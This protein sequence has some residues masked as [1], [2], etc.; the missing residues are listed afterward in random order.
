MASN[1]VSGIVL[2]LVLLGAALTASAENDD[3]ANSS[4]P[5]WAEDGWNHLALFVGITD[6]GGDTG[7]SLG[8]DYERRLT[9]L[10]GIGG[11]LEY[12]GSDL[13][14]GLAA[15]SFNWHVWKELKVLAAPGVEIEDRSGSF[16]LRLAVE[17]GFDI[18]KG[19]EAAP[20]L[21]F[22][23]TSEETAI[24]IGAGFGKSF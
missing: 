2:L 22:D 9:R 20:A 21:S 8:V 19:W 12:T 18:G 11:T 16:L 3:S 5:E 4:R 7:P 24:V 23:F 6:G 15:V 10:F 1:W 13:R 17:Y 14:D